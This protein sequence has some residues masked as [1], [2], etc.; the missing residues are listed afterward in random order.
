MTIKEVSEKYHISADTLRYYERVGMIP[1]VPRTESGIRNY[2]PDEC[3]WV[4][5]AIC[6]R[7]AGL[8]I[9]AMI[10]YVKLCQAGN[11]TI[12]AR[13]RLLQCQ[14]DK[15]LAQQAQTAETL[16][17]LNHKIDIYEQAIATGRLQW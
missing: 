17:R 2:G 10:E 5:L 16:E 14:K 3:G 1:P 11:A 12:A 15:L 4:E 6:M 13:L 7:R 9:E 8:P